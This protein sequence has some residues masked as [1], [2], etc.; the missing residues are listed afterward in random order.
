MSGSR[1]YGSVPLRTSTTI[2]VLYLAPDN[3]E[4]HGI[5]GQ[6]RTVDLDDSPNIEYATLSYVWGDPTLPKVTI[7]CNG[8]NIQ[9]TENCLAALQHLRADLC[10][11]GLPIWIDAICIDQ[12]SQDE[13]DMQLPLMGRIYTET[14]KGYIWLGAG[15]TATNHAMDYLANDRLPFHSLARRRGGVYTEFL[16][17]LQLAYHFFILFVG[18]FVIWDV[19][20]SGIA[21]P[22][23]VDHLAGIF[24]R[25]GLTYAPISRALNPDR[26]AWL[27]K[28]TTWLIVWGLPAN[29]LRDYLFFNIKTPLQHTIVFT[30]LV[31]TWC[32]TRLTPRYPREGLEDILSREWIERLWTLQ[33]AILPKNSYLVCGTKRVPLQS[34]LYATEHMSYFESKKLFHGTTSSYQSWRRLQLFRLLGE[35]NRSK[36]GNQTVSLGLQL[37][38]NRKSAEKAWN[39]SLGLTFAYRVLLWLITALLL[40]WSIYTFFRI[41][42][43]VW[44]VDAFCVNWKAYNTQYAEGIRCN[45]HA[46]Q[47]LE[48]EIPSSVIEAIMVEISMRQSAPERPED[49]YFAVLGLIGGVRPSES[50][51]STQHNL[52]TIY[53]ELFVSLVEYTG[54]LSILLFTSRRTFD[55]A[56]SWIVDWRDVPRCWI[57]ARYTHESAW[58]SQGRRPVVQVDNYKGAALDSASVWHFDLARGFG[59]LGVQGQIIG[60]LTRSTSWCD[61]ESFLLHQRSPDDFFGL[62]LAAFQD[63]MTVMPNIAIRKKA[64]E[65]V[66]RF[67]EV[68]SGKYQT[69]ISRGWQ[70]ILCENFHVG[71]GALQDEM[72]QSAE[73]EYG[74]SAPRTV[75]QYHMDISK[76][77]ADESMAVVLVQCSEP[78][79][80]DV[81]SGIAPANA[82]L[83]DTVALIAGVPTPMILRASTSSGTFRVVGPAVLPGMMDGEMWEPARLGGLV[84]V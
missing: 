43:V 45:D 20:S 81:A 53:R 28:C 32:L 84:L 68:C 51:L 22:M 65:G 29:A 52:V 26:K 19:M 34:I 31:A 13:K 38:S 42:F 14:V 11:E 55:N 64:A 15:N 24:P 70:R 37:R 69:C 39:L 41:C 36:P 40:E 16:T 7:I 21:D 72:R 27:N 44:G 77:L 6:L 56:A 49:K 4:D 74:E 18:R 25:L 50:P 33:E 2:R 54:S 60:N 5:N 10:R 12:A 59:L 67:F 62:S 30:L 78:H 35:R 48:G 73:Y 66:T 47:N 9:I 23:N 63:S 80:R 57:K 61:S 8:E 75:W 82:Q 46:T 79:G 71:K 58:E 17:T 3:P 1:V 76:F 83:G